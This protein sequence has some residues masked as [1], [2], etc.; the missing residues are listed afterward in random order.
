MREIEVKLKVNNLNFLEKEL[1]KAGCEFSEPI[2]QHDAIYSSRNINDE[3]DKSKEGDVI[4]RI[5][6]QNGKAELNLKKQ[7][8]FEMDNLE[9]ETEIENPDSVHQMLLILGWKPVIEV[10]KIRKKVKFK[11]YEICLDRVEK[12]GDFVEIE[13]MT[14]DSADPKE[15]R[16]ELFDVMKQFGSEKDEETRGYDTQ[17]YQLENKK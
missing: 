16:K 12:L 15:V 17:I 6:K 10:K 13:K 4:I 3:F 11:E 2:F 14:E 7:K 5:R 1:S 9:Y 8:S